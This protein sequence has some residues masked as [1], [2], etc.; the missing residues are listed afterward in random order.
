MLK[1]VTL[2]LTLSSRLNANETEDWE[3]VGNRTGDPSKSDIPED[4]SCFNKTTPGTSC[5]PGISHDRD[6]PLTF[7]GREVLL[8]WDSPGLAVGP[9]N[10]YVTSTTAG[11]PQF[12]AWLGQFNL[13]FTP[14]TKTGP[15]SGKTYQPKADT[16]ETDPALNG[17]AFIALTDV[18]LFVTP[19]N[20]SLI[21]PH[22]A[23]LGLYQ[24][25]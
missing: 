1:Y 13:T 23:A 25:G 17:T 5:S 16:F 21:N 10:S 19:F 22:V 15:N 6:A 14:L 3:V 7:P 4:E 12:V 24:A 11:E 2:F 18:D 20:I 8:T 9:N